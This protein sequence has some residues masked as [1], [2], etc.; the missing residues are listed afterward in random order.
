MSG[1]QPPRLPPSDF[2]LAF[3]DPFHRTKCSVEA[4][5]RRVISLLA[6]V[7]VSC[8]AHADA[9]DVL[10]AAL[11]ARVS[12]DFDA[13]ISL[14]TLPIETSTLLSDTVAVVLA[15]RGIAYD[16]QG[17]INKVIADFA[18]AIELKPNPRRTAMMAF[19]SAAAAQSPCH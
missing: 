7:V 8:S 13:A 3:V 17:Q 6:A 15:S 19:G 14:Y 9:L 5:T 18:R 16:T 4:I 2:R 12:G 10:N 11:A 1:W